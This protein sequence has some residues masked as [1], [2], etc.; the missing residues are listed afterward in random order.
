MHRNCDPKETSPLSCQCHVFCPGDRKVTKEPNYL[1]ICVTKGVL[2]R[3]TKVKADEEAVTVCYGTKA[4]LS[5]SNIV[6]PS[7]SKLESKIL[8]E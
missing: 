3:T 6:Q 7:A 4:P 2:I 5:L 1:L 8:D